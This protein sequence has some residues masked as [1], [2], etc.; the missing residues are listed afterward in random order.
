MTEASAEASPSAEV[1]PPAKP[2]P[3]MV[4]SVRKVRAAL[5]DRD[6][7]APVAESS[8]RVLQPSDN[9]N[10]PPKESILTRASSSVVAAASRR[11]RHFTVVVGAGDRAIVCEAGEAGGGST[12][13]A[14]E[15]E[16][17]EALVQ[18]DVPHVLIDVLANNMTRLLQLFRHWD[19]NETG[20]VSRR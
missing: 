8:K 2:L 3:S 16:D 9:P 10:R 4:P 14:A 11:A 1:P 15:G 6:A 18:V 17:G 5:F 13:A 12:G 7:P 19:S 20:K